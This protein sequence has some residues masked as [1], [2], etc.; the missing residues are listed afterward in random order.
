MLAGCGEA[1][2]LV[3]AYDPAGDRADAFGKKWNTPVVQSE[4]D[5]LE[6]CE[7]VFICT[8]TAEHR[9]LVTSA[10]ERGCHIF[11]EKPLAFD[12]GEAETMVDIVR[13]AGVV[14]TVG[15]ILRSTPALIA[16]RELIAN[17]DVGRPMSVVFRDD[18]YIPIQGMYESDWRADRAK[19]GRGALLE[20]SI[21]DLDLLEWLIGPIERVAA[22]QEFYHGLDGIEDSIAVLARFAS[23][24]TATLSSIWH[25]ITSRPSQRRIEVFCERA[26]FTIEGEWFGPVHIEAVGPDGEERTTLEGEALGQWLADRQIDVEWP[27]SR[28]LRAIRAG[29]E[30]SPTFTDALRAHQVVDAAYRSAANGGASIPIPGRAATDATPR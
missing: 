20:H 5:V 1:Y 25:D 28:F 19:A 13:R 17:P 11:C 21:H 3:A 8:W 12:A 29:D 23:G 9:R 7:A 14:N 27:Q 22:T 6:R 15:L 24:A 18:Q 2:E 30:C 26:L 4:D 10:A 16:L